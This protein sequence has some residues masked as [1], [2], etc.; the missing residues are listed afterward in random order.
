[1][2]RRVS[3]PGKIIL[4]GEYG[5]R[6]LGHPSIAV[7][8]NVRLS[9]SFEPGENLTIDWP[10]IT[11]RSDWQE[12]LRNIWKL[13]GGK[14]GAIRIE[15]T[16]PLGK[17][18]GSSTALTIALSR[19][20][21]GEDS[22]DEAQRIED[23]VNP[24]HSGLDFEVI[25]R[26]TPI[27]FSAER[28]AEPVNLDPHLLDGAF[29]IDTGSPA[30]TTPEL[31]AWVKGRKAEL[32]EVS[33]TLGRCTQR[34]TEFVMLSVVEAR[35]A[36][37]DI[38]RDHHRAQI[39]LGVVPAPVQELIAKIETAGGA[40]KVIGAGGRKTGAGMVLAVG[41]KEATLAAQPFP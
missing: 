40:A 13:L 5:G 35:Q 6:I 27:R 38:I 21:L 28:G 14:D 36:L 18:M 33:E 30:E 41:I 31:V 4:S 17:G 39:A 8:A 29:L 34:L 32:Q 9:A 3:A 7:P 25:W 37:P 1:V 19:L 12:Y 15:N 2:S 24:G 23:I 11:G 20:V 22:R 16:I 10:E 26:Q